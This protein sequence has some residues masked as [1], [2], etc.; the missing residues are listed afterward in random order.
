M[1]YLL[2]LQ[3]I[4]DVLN[5][6]SE[7]SWQHQRFADNLLFNLEGARYNESGLRQLKESAQ[8]HVHEF[9]ELDLW[10]LYWAIKDLNWNR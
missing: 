1:G 6:I 3:E 10:D 5:D 2:D 9:G 7:L 4:E 8:L